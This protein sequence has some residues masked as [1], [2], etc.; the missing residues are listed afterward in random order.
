MSSSRRVRIS[1]GMIAGHARHQGGAGH[2]RLRQARQLVED[3]ASR[4]R[5]GALAG[6]AAPA[7]GSRPRRLRRSLAGSPAGLR[8]WR[9]LRAR[10]RCSPS[11]GRRLTIY[12]SSPC[13]TSFPWEIFYACD[14]TLPDPAWPS[15]QHALD[16]L[17]QQ[18]C[19]KI[20]QIGVTSTTP[21]HNFRTTM[22]NHTPLTGAAELVAHL[23]PSHVEE[24]FVY[25]GM[26][27]TPPLCCRRAR[28]ATISWF[29]RRAPTSSRSTNEARP[30]RVDVVDPAAPSSG[31]KQQQGIRSRRRRHHRQPDLLD[32]LARPQQQGRSAGAALQLP[33]DR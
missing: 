1:C 24:D 23:P 17:I 5:R 14:S 7:S 31:T 6:A 26:W 3:A 19:D 8:G 22:N 29:P 10:R 27:G 12:L 25:R 32:L 33:S 18:A 15:K 16:D 11:P 21:N 20:R 4:S 28:R 13:L 30:I 9:R 2:R